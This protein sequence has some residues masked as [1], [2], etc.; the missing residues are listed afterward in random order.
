MIL[1]N[2]I[3]FIL[4]SVSVAQMWNY[5]KIFLP[6]RNAIAKSLLLSKPLLCMECS[7]FWIGVITSFFYNPLRGEF[8]SITATIFAGLL[9]H[10]VASYLLRLYIKLI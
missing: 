2:I 4:L 7:S 6:V 10:L 3:V 1:S 9:T 8:N 5:S